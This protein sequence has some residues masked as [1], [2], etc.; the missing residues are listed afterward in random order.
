M[1]EAQA[2]AALPSAP[3][4]AVTSTSDAQPADPQVQPTDHKAIK[5]MLY[6]AAVK[7]GVNPYLVLGLAWHESGW[8]P[9]IVSSAGAVGIM[10]VMPS[11]AA[12]AGPNLLHRDVNLFN[13]TDNID[14]GTALLR[15]ELDHF[16]NDYVKALVAYY[17]GGGAVRDW[18]AL[19]SDERRYV[20]S[21]FA[22]AELFATGRD[23]A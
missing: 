19:T 4:D 3:A 18:S 21:V 1:N 11:T 20:L 6:G 12:V 8:Q 16:G 7:R 5:S 14:M 2:P 10:Q 23:P 22:D 13:P 9:S 15:D 17:A